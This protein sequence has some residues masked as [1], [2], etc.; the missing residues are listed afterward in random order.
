MFVNRLMIA[1]ARQSNGGF[2][3]EGP[4]GVI[5]AWPETTDTLN[6]E[7]QTYWVDAHYF[8]RNQNKDIHIIQRGFRMSTIWCLCAGINSGEN[9]LNMAVINDVNTLF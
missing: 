8:Q 5:V 3:V 7:E 4:H 2:T 1:L 9:A 6:D